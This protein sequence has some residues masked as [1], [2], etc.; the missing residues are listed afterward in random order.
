MISA[1]VLAGE[2]ARAHGRHEEA[3]RNY[4]ACCGAYI[5]GKQRGAERFAAAFAP[6]TAWGL[7]FRNLVIN[8]A[9]FPGVARFAIGRDIVDRLASAQYEWPAPRGRF[10]RLALAAATEIYFPQNTASSAPFSRAGDRAGAELLGGQRRERRRRRETPRSPRLDQ[11]VRGGERDAG[12]ALRLLARSA[13]SGR[14]APPTRSKAGAPLALFSSGAKATGGASLESFA[15]LA[16]TRSPRGAQHDE[17][18][19]KR[20]RAAAAPPCRRNRPRGW[21]GRSPRRSARSGRACR[22]R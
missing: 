7:R 1:Y 11:G 12:D 5:E 20:R 9:A 16:A 6:R 13:R 8:A 10:P 3:F 2:L 21:R 22:R 15:E 14:R 4:E 18:A 19:R 17:V